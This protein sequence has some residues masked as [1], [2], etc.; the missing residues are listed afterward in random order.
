LSDKVVRDP[1]HGYITLTEQ[2]RKFIDTPHFQRLRRIRQSGCYTV[3]PSANHTRFEHSM[4][5]MHLGSRVMETILANPGAKGVGGLARYKSTVRYACLLHDLGHAP[6]SHI[7]ESF[8][9]QNDLG[10]SSKRSPAWNSERASPT[11][12]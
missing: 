1:I 4:G 12:T 3:Y 5:V 9:D 11:S 2:D 8:F 10:G 6:L 7:G